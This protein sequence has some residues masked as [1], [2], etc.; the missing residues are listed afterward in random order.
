MLLHRARRSQ[1]RLNGLC[2]HGDGA[3]Q[4]VHLRR[5]VVEEIIESLLGFIQASAGTNH[6]CFE[7]IEISFPFFSLQFWYECIIFSFLEIHN[8]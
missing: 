2:L 4:L 3:V 1:R 8:L 7:Q 6:F 5:E